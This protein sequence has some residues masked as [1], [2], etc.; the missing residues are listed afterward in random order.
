MT[1]AS[2]NL[3]SNATTE[4]SSRGDTNL[5]ILESS[6]LSEDWKQ[7]FNA[8]QLVEKLGQGSYGCVM[9]AICKVTG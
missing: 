7:V 6:N 3:D 9:K 4:P 8:Y 5:K 2:A 1:L